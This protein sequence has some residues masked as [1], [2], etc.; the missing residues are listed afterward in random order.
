[1]KRL[2][3]DSRSLATGLLL[4]SGSD[5]GHK[6]NRF[7]FF[8]T[9]AIVVL[10]L[11]FGWRTP[12]RAPYLMDDKGSIHENSSIRSF[13]GSPSAWV[14]RGSGNTVQGRPLLNVTLALN[15]AWSRL[16]PAS[17]RITN[18]VIHG[19]NALLLFGVM[20]LLLQSTRFPA[21][22]R[23][24]WGLLSATTSILW[25]CN[26]IGTNVVTYIVQRAESLATL[27]I[28][29]TTLL[30]LLANQLRPS[31]FMSDSLGSRLITNGLLIA[32]IISA[33]AASFSKETAI[34][35]PLLIGLID[36]IFFPDRF[37]AYPRGLRYFMLGLVLALGAGMYVT[38]SMAGSRNGTVGSGYI[39]PLEYLFGQGEVILRYVWG[40]LTAD[41]RI[42]DFGHLPPRSIRGWIC[43]FI[44]AIV[45][46]VAFFEFLYRRSFIGWAIVT[47]LVILGPTSSLI[48]VQA[49]VGIFH[50]FYLPSAILTGLLTVVLFRFSSRWRA[51]ELAFNCLSVVVALWWL[52]AT[53]QRNRAYADPM[54]IWRESF[55]RWPWSGRVV[56]LLTRVAAKQGKW[57]EVDRINQRY[58]DA[59]GLEVGAIRNL[60][61]VHYELG[62]IDRALAIANELIVRFPDDASTYHNLSRYQ[63]DSGD[64]DGALTSIEKA[65][66]L[67]E[68]DPLYLV[69]RGE[70]YRRTGQHDLVLRDFTAAIQQ[71]GEAADTFFSLGSFWLDQGRLERAEPCFRKAVE[72]KADYHEAMYW[73]AVA[74]AS[75]RDFTEAEHFITEALIYAK[76]DQ[77]LQLKEIIA[78]K[79]ASDEK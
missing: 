38:F 3:H 44:L 71:D 6:A 42:F 15:Y 72:L 63:R 13:T 64:L 39:S 2:F 47:M 61:Q 12:L 1:M 77:Y 43:F 53:V 62:Q 50:R 27:W 19:V 28:L 10:V 26:P 51:G 40:F 78:T 49:Q 55:E 31:G 25:V 7:W 48:P 66:K 33:V 18:L 5:S 14:P 79:K 32:S 76:T 36:Y 75:R 58:I 46:C 16:D 29:L 23:D 60:A 54:V 67:R 35:I 73:L 20:A 45:T 30:Y 69:S 9:F 37:K 59:G 57:D 21:H 34:V 56:E 17:Y 65:L 4:A 74:L 41:V 68:D 22:I 24:H 8:V 70:I 11:G 52:S